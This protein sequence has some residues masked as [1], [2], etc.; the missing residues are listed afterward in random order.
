[1]KK[2]LFVV[3]LASCTLSVV[4]CLS[5]ASEGDLSEK[6]VTILFTHA[7]EGCLEPCG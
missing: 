1:M 5:H 2:W 4:L 3:F 6:K 7:L